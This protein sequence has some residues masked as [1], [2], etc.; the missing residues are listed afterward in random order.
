VLVGK[1]G[2]VKDVIYIDGP[3]ALKAAAD[4]CARTAVFKPALMDQRPVEVWVLMPV[5]FKLR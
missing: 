1:D 3:E 4:D 2:R 5:T